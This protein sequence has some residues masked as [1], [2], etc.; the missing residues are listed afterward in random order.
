MKKALYWFIPI[1]V[2]T[3]VV[4]LVSDS[5]LLLAT[6]YNNKVGSIVR[7]SFLTKP[8]VSKAI[9]KFA[10]SS[11]SKWL[12]KPYIKKYNI[13]IQEA[14]RANPRDYTSLNDFFTRK[15]KLTARPI[16]KKP[17]TIISPADGTLYA[18]E[19]I[20]ARTELFVKGKLFDIKNFLQNED[21]AKQFY[22]GTLVLIYLS[23]ADYHRFHFPCD[24]IP[25]K[26]HQINGIYE[27]VH[28]IAFNAG[29]QP[30]TENE[31]QIITIKTNDC[32]TIALIAVG[33]LCVGRIMQTYNSGQQ[34]EK[35]NE[36]GYFSFGGSTL[37]LL[38]EKGKINITENINKPNFAN[39][40]I[41]IKMG[42]QIAIKN[43]K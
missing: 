21:Q 10:D 14:K 4:A 34:Y 20:G 5:N 36:M 29:V 13:N 3:L 39:T 18:V 25:S 30:L 43:K 9:G 33:A 2:I 17:A 15:L 7:R 24:G 28:P 27:S 6:I 19:N 37:V 32:G 1:F 40:G 35:G 31:R 41:S 22:G 8:I 26:A 42:Q 12:I 11:L 38:F 16:D 23:P